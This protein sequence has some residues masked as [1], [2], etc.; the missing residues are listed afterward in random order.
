MI[1]IDSITEAER[2]AERR[3]SETVSFEWGICDGCLAKTSKPRLLADFDHVRRCSACYD[4]LW[5]LDCY[6]GHAC[7]PAESGR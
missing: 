4:K 5:C 2:A 6:P 3:A 7:T 1:E